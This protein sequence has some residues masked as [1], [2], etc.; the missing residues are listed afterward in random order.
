MGKENDKII[1]LQSQWNSSVKCRV[2]LEVKVS[3]P[4]SSGL[5][6]FQEQWEDTEALGWK[7]I[8]SCVYVFQEY[9]DCNVRKKL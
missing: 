3:S 1:S 9:S 4:L 7:V 2:G 6:L 5:N 8:H